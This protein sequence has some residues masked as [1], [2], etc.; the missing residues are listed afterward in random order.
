MDFSINFKSKSKKDYSFDNYDIFRSF[1]SVQIKF[2]SNLF[3][4]F[5]LKK[6]NNEPM[7]SSKHLSALLTELDTLV[8]KLIDS[9][10]T[11]QQKQVVFNN[12]STSAKNKMALWL[13]S[14][15]VLTK[16]YIDCY[17]KFGSNAAINFINYATGAALPPQ[18]TSDSFFAAISLYEYKNSNIDYTSRLDAE[19]AS[20]QETLKNLRETCTEFEKSYNQQNAQIETLKNN[21]TTDFGTLFHKNATEHDTNQ[22]QLT[23]K[24]DNFFQDAQNKAIELE[25][26][27]QE[28]LRLAKPAEYWK[29]SALKYAKQGYTFMTILVLWVVCGFVYVSNFFNSWLQGESHH[30][31]LTTLEGVVIFGT[32]ITIYTLLAKAISKLTFSSMHLMRDSE[33]REQLTYL[34]L[35]L[36]KENELDKTSRDIILQSLF[37][38][39]ETGLLN[40][41]SSPTMPGVA[42]LIK[43]LNSK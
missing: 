34:Y 38:R 32:A 40:S 41:D 10:T 30:L 27:Y 36:I 12:F 14:E 15:D 33:E 37:S 29:K 4:Q 2:W 21:M 13:D 26:L 7:S 43:Q 1:L 20:I 19:N 23:S 24:F 31:N 42:E 3:E 25:N 5:D 28:K 39:T 11:E 35:S 16:P 6:T 18:F 8:S 17:R 9:D 22:S